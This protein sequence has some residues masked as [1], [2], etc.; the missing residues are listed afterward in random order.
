MWRLRRLHLP[1]PCQLL[2]GTP[3]FPATATLRHAEGVHHPGIIP[4]EHLFGAGELFEEQPVVVVVEAFP[5]AVL[6]TADVVGDGVVVRLVGGEVGDV[7]RVLGEPAEGTELAVLTLATAGHADGALLMPAQELVLLLGSL[8]GQALL[9]LPLG[10]L[11]G[12]TEPL[13]LLGFH[14]S[15]LLTGSSA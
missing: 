15:A 10:T 6:G 1:E 14:V 2:R 13:F 7:R 4:I 3:R 5:A 11:G 8:D 12:R 9:V